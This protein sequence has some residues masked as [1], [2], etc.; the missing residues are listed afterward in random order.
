MGW[1]SQ[2]DWAVAFLR[3]VTGITVAAHGY[4]KI[5]QGG[6]LAGT[7]GWLDSIGMRPGWL[8]AR[9]V[10]FTE[11]G[12]GL[13]LAIGLLTT[14]A[15][16]GIIGVMSVAVWTV[17]RKNG[18]FNT[19]SGWEYNLVL[20]SIA[21]TLAVTGA[22]QISIDGAITGGFGLLNGGIGLLIA[23]VLGIGGAAAHIAVFYRPGSTAASSS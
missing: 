5:F 7:A 14:L 12:A 19:T 20:A 6:R 11:L 9:L 10:A 1:V 22:G 23:L 15:A 13:L 2:F 4:N 16:A 18:F 21:L 17:H 3:V 8:H